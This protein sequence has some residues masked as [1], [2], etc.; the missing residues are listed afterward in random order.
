MS[1]LSDRLYCSKHSVV[2]CL[3]FARFR[4][5]QMLFAATACISISSSAQCVAS[6]V[7][8]NVAET[9]YA[10]N[11]C[12]HPMNRWLD[13]HWIVT[14]TCGMCFCRPHMSDSCHRFCS[15]CV[16]YVPVLCVLSRCLLSSDSCFD[17][18]ARARSRVTNLLYLGMLLV[19]LSSTHYASL[20]TFCRIG[21]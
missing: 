2:V 7:L 8:L 20:A 19:R 17:F 1:W 12:M 6:W 3:G 5:N 10:L 18:V 14:T 11:S 9:H 15:H 13:Q 16:T 4:V 21:D